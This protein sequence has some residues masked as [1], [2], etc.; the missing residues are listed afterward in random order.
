MAARGVPEKFLRGGEKHVPPVVG[1]P[2]MGTGTGTPSIA[3]GR[4]I[5][6]SG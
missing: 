3:I 1:T 2:R 5:P 6:M 4:D